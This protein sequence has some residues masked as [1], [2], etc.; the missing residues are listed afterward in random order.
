MTVIERKL[1]HLSRY[2]QMLLRCYDSTTKAYANYGA[3]GITVCDEWLNS[4][5]AFALW[6]DNNG[7]QEDL[8]L[9]KDILCDEKGISPKVYGPSTCKFITAEEN[10]EYM[11]SH[12]LRQA[13]ASYDKNGLLVQTYE[14][15]TKAGNAGQALNIGRAARGL[16]K[17]AGGY[18][19]RYIESVDTAPVSIELPKAVRK[20][21]SICEVDKDGNIL[22]IY[23]NAP[24][25]SEVTGLNRTSISQV[26]IGSRGSVFGRYFKHYIE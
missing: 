2:T 4:F 3:K 15:I 12:T 19:W 16:R 11:L 23:E 5:D 6:C 17:T 22:A 1:K 7:Y 24:H 18:Y 13:V 26:V 25:A 14:S 10:R 20:G 9:D 8:V 21:N